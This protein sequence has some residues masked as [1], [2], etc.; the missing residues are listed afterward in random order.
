MKK[1]IMTKG[2]PA[3][4]KTTWAKLQT[5]CKRINKDDLRAMIDNSVWSNE[6]EKLIVDIRN[7]IIL[8]MML[9]G[10]NII[11]D[12]TNLDPVH[13]VALSGLVDTW[14]DMVHTLDAKE[15]YEFEIKDFTE[16]SLETCLQR[17]RNREKSVPTRVIHQMYDCI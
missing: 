2:L 3:S 9:A 7:A 15:Q 1:L 11:I 10:S 12:D 6:N 16:V 4:G 8:Q 17:N 14:N 5:D 13:E